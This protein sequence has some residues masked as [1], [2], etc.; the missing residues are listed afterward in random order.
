[1]T[2][3]DIQAVLDDIERTVRGHPGPDSVTG[4]LVARRLEQVDFILRAMT[5]AELASAGPAD[6]I[7]RAYRNSY[8]PGR[9][10]TFPLW[11]DDVLA[12]RVG[13]AH[14]AN[15]GV[16]VELEAHAQ[17][18]TA[19]SAH[20]SAHPYDREVPL[21]FLGA[22]ISPLRDTTSARTVD[23]APTLAEL[24]D[25]TPPPTVDGIVLEIR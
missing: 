20:G 21:I 17:I 23:I 10:T 5:P 6:G 8:I 3:E 22:G 15:W 1:V 16:V 4:A 19:R 7:V 25:L 14:P 2:Q 18:Y 12:G 24:A 9:S 11:T 13:P